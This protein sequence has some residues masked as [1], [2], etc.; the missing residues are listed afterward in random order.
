MRVFTASILACMMVSVLVVASPV[1]VYG[2]PSVGVKEGDWI[3]YEVNAAGVGSMPPTHDVRWFRI[4]VLP[5]VQDATF[6]VN[7]TSRYANGTVGSAVWKFNF[8]EGNVE[9]WIIIP[10]NLGAGDTFYDYSLHTGVPVNVTIQGEEQKTVFGATRTVTYG[11]DKLRHKEWDKATGVFIGTT[12]YY[13]NVTTKTGWHIEDLTVTVQATA[14]NM[15]SHDLIMGLKPLVFY[16]LVTVIAVIAAFMLVLVVLDRKK[17]SPPSLSASAQGKIAVLTI[18]LVILFEFASMFLFPFYAVGLST[19]EINL[20]MQTIWTGMVFV[21]MWFRMKGNYFAHEITML[22]VI[23]AW[24]IG[25]SFVLFMDP[26]SASTE[27]FSNTPLRLIMNALHGIFSIPALV[28]GTWLVA[29]WRP[30][31]TTFP[32]K[33]RRLAQLTLLCWIPSYVVGFLDFM[34]LHTTIFG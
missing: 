3:E 13:K 1:L 23:A 26:F 4:E 28:F 27:V 20:I 2:A 25:V 30:E 24:W 19:S 8:T 16:A 21:S 5:P 32:A 9:G 22:I 12:E 33:T 11:Q 10:A 34:V 6:S 17:I 29:L 15:W 18:V 7:L 31:S 14:T